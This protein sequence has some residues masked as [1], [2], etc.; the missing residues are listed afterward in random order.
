MPKALVIQLGTAMGVQIVSSQG[1]VST[2]NANGIFANMSRK[3]LFF[4]C[5]KKKKKLQLGDSGLKIT[6]VVS[7]LMK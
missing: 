2:P 4:F 6:N 3:H 1:V 5:E 7:Q